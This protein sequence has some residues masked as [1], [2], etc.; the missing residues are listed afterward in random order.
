MGLTA[1]Q[2]LDPRTIHVRQQAVW[3]GTFTWEQPSDPPTDPVTYV[4]GDV[5]GYSA[6]F[7][8]LK[9]PGGEALVTVVS[10]DTVDGG[11]DIDEVTATFVVHLCATDTALLTTD[12]CY[13][14]DL[15]ADDDPCEVVSLASG[16]ANLIR[17]G[18][19]YPA[20]A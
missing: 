10:P 4:P 15:I 13:V 2:N 16:W 7:R 8:W 6:R 20:V 17:V 3:R 11:I 18:E 14:L 12:G 1:A 9:K 19:A 5:T